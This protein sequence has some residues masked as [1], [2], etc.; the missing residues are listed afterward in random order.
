MNEFLQKNW[1]VVAAFTLPLLLVF[2][3]VASV[4]VPSLFIQTQ[5]SFV[6]AVCDDQYNSYECLEYVDDYYRIENG[7]LTKHTLPE[8]STET[9]RNKT[10]RLYNER[11]PAR[12]FM[13]S[14]LTNT[15][16]ELTN[17]MISTLTMSDELTSPD[18]IRV[19]CGY[20]Y[21]GDFFFI[22]DTHH[23]EYACYLQDGVRQKKVV[24]ETPLSSYYYNN[25]I[26]FIGWI[27]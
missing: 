18:N 25:S 8:S 6:Y 16:T 5:Y 4:Y 17:D 26:R 13:Y 7:K 12:L 20:N 3:I 19:D 14:P 22:F 1:P 11:F 15:S 27:L 9:Y 21:G 10:I 23:S 24:L 2:G